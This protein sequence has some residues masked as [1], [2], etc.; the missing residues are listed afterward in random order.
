MSPRP[1]AH[2]DHDRHPAPSCLV[3]QDAADRLTSMEQTLQEIRTALVGNE[4]MGQFGLV[5]RVNNHS[6]RIKRLER[7]GMYLLGFG[8]AISL[9]YKFAVDWLPR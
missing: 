8:G 7:A 6:S 5:S 3:P 4:A 2:H 9:L 1:D